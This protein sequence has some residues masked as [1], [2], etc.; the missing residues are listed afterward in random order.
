LKKLIKSSRINT[1][2]VAFIFTILSSSVSAASFLEISGIRGDSQDQN[3]QGSIDVVTWSWGM[4]NPGSV[5]TGGGGSGSTKVQEFTFVKQSDSATTELMA[6]ILKAKT[7]S[8]VVLIVTNPQGK[9]TSRITF[10]NV[11][12][13]SISTNDEG[14]ESISF[15]MSRFELMTVNIDDTGY[16]TNR[17]VVCWDIAAN[18]AC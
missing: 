2:V 15:E 10:S 1:L 17:Q 12:L 4:Y 3:F 7:L 14:M 16:V 8:N 5:L 9:V 13:K 6:Y 11:F 18:A